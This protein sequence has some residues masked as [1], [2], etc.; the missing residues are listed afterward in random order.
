M[1]GV[2][3]E[4]HTYIGWLEANVLAEAAGVGAPN[5][6]YQQQQQLLPKKTAMIHFIDFHLEM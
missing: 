3:H 6:H 5:H 1:I 4:D 2:T